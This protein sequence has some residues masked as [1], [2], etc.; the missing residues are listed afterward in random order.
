MTTGQAVGAARFAFGFQGLYLQTL[1]REACGFVSSR[2][3]PQLDSPIYLIDD[4][5]RSHVVPP[6]S[7]R[8][9]KMSKLP[10]TNTNPDALSQH[11]AFDDPNITSSTTAIAS[12]S[13]PSS[14]KTPSTSSSLTRPTSSP[15]AASPVTPEKWS[16][17]TKA[18]GTNPKELT[19]TTNSTAPGS[20]PASASSSP[21]APFGFPAPPTSVAR[22]EGE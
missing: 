18:N 6:A 14:L 15:T 1:S 9:R 21:T 7:C 17:S 8:L 16:P 3:R 12:N 11:I 19:P 2:A 13:S 10:A 4:P 20:P 22:Q 5:D